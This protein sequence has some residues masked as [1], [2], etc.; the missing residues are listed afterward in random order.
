[1][2]CV[3][4][5]GEAWEVN[6]DGYIRQTGDENDHTLYAVKG[7]KNR[8]G[9]RI[10]YRWGE[11]KGMEK[12]IP[13]SSEVMGKMVFDK[14]KDW[15]GLSRSYIEH[16]YTQLEFFENAGVEDAKKLICFLSKNT[17]VE[18]SIV[19]GSF[20]DVISTTIYSSH[21][22]NREYMGL[23]RAISISA[24]NNLYFFFHTHPRNEVFGWLSNEK[25]RN[26]CRGLLFEDN[27]PN[28]QIG[29]IHKG[30]FF[31]LYGRRVMKRNIW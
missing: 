28:A 27:S 17:D 8:F 23:N 11:Q 10:T 9:D 2:R 5:D 18:W 24:N 31:D 1:M 26:A 6:Q 25:D 21:K 14:S 3:D 13:V 4:P 22:N 12:S 16:D 20:N 30:L 29:V 19:G 7:R 15:D